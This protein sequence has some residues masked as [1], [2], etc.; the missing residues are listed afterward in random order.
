[1]MQFSFEVGCHR[2]KD[3]VDDNI[4]G[5]VWVVLL[6]TVLIS[7]QSMFEEHGGNSL[8]NMK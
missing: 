8:R 1:M 3:T 7:G 6:S 5:E 2:G 4:A